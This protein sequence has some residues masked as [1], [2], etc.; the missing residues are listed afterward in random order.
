M[1]GVLAGLQTGA[2][3]GVGFLD[4]NGSFRTFDV[5]P[6]SP[7]RN[8]VAR[9]INNA[10]Q[11][12]GSFQDPPANGQPRGFLYAGGTFST[13][14]VPGAELTVAY[15]INDVKHIVGA[16]LPGAVPEPGSLVLFSVG[17]LGLGG[18]A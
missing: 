18:E 13:I 11:I 3:A 8:T 6:P 16:F 2:I 9:G 14:D 12:V 1:A 4:V 5:P 17:L 15:G 7:N 10:E